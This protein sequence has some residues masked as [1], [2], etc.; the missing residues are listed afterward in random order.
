MRLWVGHLEGAK[1]V[2]EKIAIDGGYTTVMPP[3]ERCKLMQRVDVTA[4]EDAIYAA[5]IPVGPYAKRHKPRPEPETVVYTG[6]PEALQRQYFLDDIQQH[7][8]SPGAIKP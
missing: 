6:I 2:R 3:D 7:P 1:I 5:G 8:E 4:Q